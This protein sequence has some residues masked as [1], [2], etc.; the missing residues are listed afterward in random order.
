MTMAASGAVFPLRFESAELRDAVRNLS[1]RQGVS[2]NRFILEAVAARG[3]LVA[4]VMEARLEQSMAVLHRYRGTW[5]ESDIANF[6]HGEISGEDPAQ[7]LMVD[8][9]EAAD[10][11]P[12]GILR[13]FAHPLER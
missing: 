3:G 9:D 7:G 10:G 12:Y 4:K 6:A 8:P 2:M 11:D 1:E 5:T 13:A